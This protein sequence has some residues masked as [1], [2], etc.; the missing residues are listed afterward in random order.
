VSAGQS[1]FL[2]AFKAVAW[3]FFGVRKNS[4]YQED[5]A[6]LSP[7]LVIAV[8]FVA[9]LLFIGLLIGLAKLAVAA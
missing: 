1:S 4:E 7:L 3:G 6:R 9:A 2:R 8:G 5:T